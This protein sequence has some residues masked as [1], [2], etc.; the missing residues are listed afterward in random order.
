MG[1]FV[2]I[3]LL[4]FFLGCS[5]ERV[6]YFTDPTGKYFISYFP[7]FVKDTRHIIFTYGKIDKKDA[8]ASYLIIPD[9]GFDG[10]RCLIKWNHD[11]AFIYEPYSKFRSVNM[12][13]EKRLQ[14][15]EIEASIFT[16]IYYDKSN[17]SYIKF[18]DEYE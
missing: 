3:L 11:T 14:L 8:P 1:R 7:Y 18:G 9:K 12:D 5:F 4:V 16:S 15:R 6:K 2:A 10:A 17:T 13:K